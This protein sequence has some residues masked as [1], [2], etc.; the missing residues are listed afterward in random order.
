M[1]KLLRTVVAVMEILGGL[2]GIGIIANT[3]LSEQLSQSAVIV[4]AGFVVV[5][6]Y[7]IAAGAALIKT[8]RLGL[9]L[10][11]IY[12]GLQ[13]PIIITSQLSFDLFSGASVNILWYET[14]FWCNLLFGSRYYFNLNS[15]EPWCFGV[16]ILALVLFILLI[17]QLWLKTDTST[18]I[19]AELPKTDEQTTAAELQPNFS[20]RNS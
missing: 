7:G 1:S 4:N 10:S 19:E 5:F 15:G 20:W 2:V 14:G 8:P 3:L 11:I 6:L 16:N 18:I 13:I 9:V 17:R 12:L